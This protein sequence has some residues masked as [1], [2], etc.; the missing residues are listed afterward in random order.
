MR[1]SIALFDDGVFR[2]EL[3]AAERARHLGRISHIRIDHDRLDTGPITRDPD[4]DP[5]ARKQRVR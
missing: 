2:V 4:R 5:D 1:R 3:R